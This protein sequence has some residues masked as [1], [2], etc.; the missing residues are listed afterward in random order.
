[1]LL[2]WALFGYFAV[3]TLLARPRPDEPR[4][5]STSLKFGLLLIALAIGLRF[6]VGADWPAYEFIFSFA[7]YADLGRLV[8]I[9]DPGYQFLNW[10]VQRASG[11]IWVVNLI[12]AT[13]FSYGLYRF[14]RGQ[15]DPWLTVVVAIPYLVVVVA[16]GYTRQAVAIGI[17]MAGLAAL[18]QKASMPRFMLYV[19]A[20]ALFH[21]TAVIVLPLVM[22]SSQ[23]SRLVNVVAGAI[24]SVVL[25]DTFLS[26][27]V[28]GFIRNY[29]TVEY[30]S[31][32]A[33]IRVVMNLVPAIALLIFR[34]G[35]RLEPVEFRIWV[36]FA[37][38]SVAMGVALFLLPS[39]TVVDRLSL[40]LI[41]IQLAVLPRL[42]LLFKERNF[43]R[44]MVILY[45][46]L[47]LFVWLNFAVHAKFWLPYQSVIQL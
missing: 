44:F 35:L 10:A 34:R 4:F 17:L 7:K 46:A 43:G 20:A 21:K 5:R 29:I 16:M 15:R 18:G 47:V 8:S 25:Y 38:A 9:G 26:S 40:Y 19:A 30:N 2:Y 12:S 37:L 1:M 14:A 32:G 28:E 13:I 24:G 27:S 42:A 22:F 45:A 11:E 6:E 31:Q 3:G 23:R 41:P 33:A 36:N 39:T